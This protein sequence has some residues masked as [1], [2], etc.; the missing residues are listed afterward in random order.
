M[1]T[2][3]LRF[4][5]RCAEFLEQEEY[6]DLPANTR[7]IYV[8]L[9]QRKKGRFD[10]VYIGMARGLRAGIRTRLRSHAKKK[11]N[12]WTHFSVY[13]VWNNVFQAEVEELEGLFRAI[14]RKDPSTNP[15]NRQRGYKKLRN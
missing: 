9:K 11:K 15:I 3:D 14:Y 1:P 8:L 7:G 5:Y 6:S 2:S 13:E 10:V 4:I 12:L